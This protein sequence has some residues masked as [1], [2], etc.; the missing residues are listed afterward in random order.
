MTRWISAF[1]GTVIAG[2]MIA[3][4]PLQAQPIAIPCVTENEIGP[5][6]LRPPP[7]HEELDQRRQGYLQRVRNRAS[8]PHAAFDLT[9]A[10]VPNIYPTEYWCVSDGG[11]HG[12]PDRLGTATSADYRPFF[13]LVF[14]PLPSEFPHIGS[15]LRN[16][17]SRDLMIRCNDEYRRSAAEYL[18][19]HLPHEDLVALYASLFASSEPHRGLSVGHPRVITRFSGSE[20]RPPIVLD[21]TAVSPENLEHLRQNTVLTEAISILQEYVGSTSQS[22][23]NVVEYCP[24]TSQNFVDEVGQG[25]IHDRAE[26]ILGRALQ[27]EQAGTGDDSSRN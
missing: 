11:C 23:Y 22:R 9:K 14:D 10:L 15:V 4:T 12:E 27:R 18:E 25:P 19:N 26:H 24:T 16:M 7:T 13:A 5:C 1:A 8:G 3:P 2:F 21:E 17:G 6:P 20:R